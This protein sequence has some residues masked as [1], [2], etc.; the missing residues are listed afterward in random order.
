M[1]SYRGRWLVRN[2]LKASGAG[3][4]GWAGGAGADAVLIGWGS[5]IAGCV[6]GAPEEGKKEKLVGGL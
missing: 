6:L 2:G 1:T 5:G 3:D 4:V